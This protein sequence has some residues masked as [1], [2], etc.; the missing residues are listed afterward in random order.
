M[1]PAT[2]FQQKMIFLDDLFRQL[3]FRGIQHVVKRGEMIER[4][5][6]VVR[7]HSGVFFTENGMSFINIPGLIV[8]Q[9]IAFNPV[10]VVG[11]RNLCIMIQPALDT[12]VFFLSEPF[13]YP[14]HDSD[15]SCLFEIYLLIADFQTFPGREAV[16][17]REKNRWTAMRF[18]PGLR[19]RRP[20]HRVRRRFQCP[21]R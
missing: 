7:S 4:F 10:G 3:F 18:W 19:F 2:T 14:V 1:I 5:N 8:S 20:P 21:G 11:N 12:G 9:L 15:P 6:D 16:L 13:Q 17:F